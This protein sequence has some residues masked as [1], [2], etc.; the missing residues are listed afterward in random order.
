MKYVTTLLA[1]EETYI[2]IFYT[3]TLG[4]SASIMYCY[5][6]NVN[7][8]F[9]LNT[10]RN[11][12][13]GALLIL[14]DETEMQ[15]VDITLSNISAF[16]NTGV[17]GLGGAGNMV[18]LAYNEAKYAL[19]INNMV[20]SYGNRYHSLKSDFISP[21]GGLYIVNGLYRFTKL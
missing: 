4:C 9:G 1:W 8:S 14:L 20:N 19:V 17:A 5:M 12:G 11:F 13:S 2:G 15:C 7:F 16:G 6:Y 21:A 3:N 10:D 18:L